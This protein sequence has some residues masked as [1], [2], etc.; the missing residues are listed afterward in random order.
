MTNSKLFSLV[1]TLVSYG[2]DTGEIPSW[3]WLNRLAHRT[4]DELIALGARRVR[5]RDGWE[6]AQRLFVREIM[7]LAGGDL[8]GLQKSVLMPLELRLAEHGGCAA[9]TPQQFA[10]RVLMA[11]P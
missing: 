3:A 2:I 7:V 8:E 1:G 4:S 10:A 11:I 6:R 5:R 9:P